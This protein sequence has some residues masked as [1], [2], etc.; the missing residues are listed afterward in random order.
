MNKETI[1]VKPP[2]DTTM[3]AWENEGGMI[4]PFVILRKEQRAKVSAILRPQAVT[5]KP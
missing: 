2:V 4:P 5:K 3:L 1:P